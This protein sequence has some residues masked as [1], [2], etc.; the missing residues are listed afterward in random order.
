MEKINILKMDVGKIHK[1]IKFFKIFIWLREIQI[2][3]TDP[4]VTMSMN[5]NKHLE[6]HTI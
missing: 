4:L 3:S 5:M 1:V 2:L 6:S